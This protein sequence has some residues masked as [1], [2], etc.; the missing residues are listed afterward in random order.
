MEER[1]K[2]LVKKLNNDDITEKE[3]VAIWDELNPLIKDNKENET[4]MLKE[5]RIPKIMPY[6]VA[7][8]LEDIRSFIQW[9]K[10]RKAYFPEK[11]SD[12]MHY[13]FIGSD[14]DHNLLDF[15]AEEKQQLKEAL[16]H[17]AERIKKSA[18]NI[19]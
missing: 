4:L 6:S 15:T 13:N 12:W 19:K 14:R 2:E 9:V 8:Q 7:S 18:E 16:F 3:R 1:I 5:M 10:I 17:L 11:D